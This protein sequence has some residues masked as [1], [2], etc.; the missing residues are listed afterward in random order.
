MPKGTY[1]QWT[2]DE[3]EQVL[4]VSGTKG[5]EQLA[6]E[7][8]LTATTIYSTRQRIRIAGGVEE[9]ISQQRIAGTP[10]RRSQPE[11]LAEQ[12]ERLYLINVSGAGR[13]GQSAQYTVTLPS[14]LAERLVAEYGRQI[15]FVPVEDGIKIVPIA[16][17]PV[18][19]LPAWAAKSD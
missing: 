14:R 3:L 8:G 10:L 11:T 15:R 17:A 2:R 1:H 6:S 7:L 13:N 12:L 4:T 18:P 5:H 19:E 16:R 9:F